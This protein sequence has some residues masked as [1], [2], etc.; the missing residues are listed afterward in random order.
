MT[1]FVTIIVCEENLGY[2]Q[3]IY[4]IIW[5]S[6]LIVLAFLDYRLIDLN[7]LY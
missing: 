5:L 1:F 2:L 4:A 3:A 7:V 6:T